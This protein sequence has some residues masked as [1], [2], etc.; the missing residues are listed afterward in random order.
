MLR[1][2]LF[3]A[4][5]LL[6]M[7]GC[8]PC[9]DID[10]RMAPVLIGTPDPSVDQFVLQAS[11]LGLT[12]GVNDSFTPGA[13]EWDG[14]RLAWETFA[15]RLSS[16]GSQAM[17][18][19]TLASE[20]SVIGGTLS[21]PVS[22]VTHR[23]DGGF[24]VGLVA[25]GPSALSLAGDAQAPGA[26]QVLTPLRAAWLDSAPLLSF[27][28]WYRPGERLPIRVT[29][30]VFKGG[31]V[32]VTGSTAL[33][34]LAVATE[35]RA[36]RPGMSDDFTLAVSTSLLA[37]LARGG[38]RPANGAAGAATTPLPEGW[39]VTALAPE[40]GARGLVVPVLAR[41]EG[42]CRFVELTAPTGPLIRDAAFAW[43]DAGAVAVT[44]QRD[45]E[46]VDHNSLANAALRALAQPLAHPPL[47]GPR[48][49]AVVRIVRNSDTAVLLDGVLGPLTVRMMAPPPQVRGLNAPPASP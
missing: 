45:A 4:T 21:F 9:S 18:G 13:I 29:D 37:A 8:A 20:Q 23:T 2:T 36:M 24:R 38:W 40:P 5:V 35:E 48:G 6:G 19:V 42:A 14:R 22:L 11:G 33:L 47:A 31:V 32:R 25:A 39:T 3:V 16:T 43:K 10:R 1:T 34:A 26:A 46:S 49:G 17:V 30:A 15:V 7:T 12:A 28:G 27:T 41:S 44:A